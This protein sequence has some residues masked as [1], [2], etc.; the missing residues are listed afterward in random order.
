MSKPGEFWI[1]P[2]NEKVWQVECSD[3]IHVREV[4][5]EYDACFEEMLG[6]LRYACLYLKS[7]NSEPHEP[8]YQM[9]KSFMNVIAKA[10]SL[11]ASKT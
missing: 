3:M 2:Y 10:E 5:P 8:E 11:K 4:S 9:V 7:G 1:D 6:E